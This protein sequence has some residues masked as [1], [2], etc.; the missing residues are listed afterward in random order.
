[1]PRKRKSYPWT[2][3]PRETLREL[4]RIVDDLYTTERRAWVA[5]SF[6]DGSEDY[7]AWPLKHLSLSISDADGTTDFQPTEAEDFFGRLGD[8]FYASS[9]S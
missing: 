2:V 8:P 1:M 4:V 7:D 3:L 5:R 6:P 9:M